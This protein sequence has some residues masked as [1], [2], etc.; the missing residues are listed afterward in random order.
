MKEELRANKRR[1]VD[2]SPNE[3]D[4]KI[5]RLT[6]YRLKANRMVAG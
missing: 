4:W 1:S 2:A 3:V 5:E 6:D